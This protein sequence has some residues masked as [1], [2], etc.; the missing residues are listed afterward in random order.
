[1]CGHNSCAFSHVAACLLQAPAWLQPSR[2]GIEIYPGDILEA[3]LPAVM[4]HTLLFKWINIPGFGGRNQSTHPCARR[5][6][7]LTVFLQPNLLSTYCRPHTYVDGANIKPNLA[8]PELGPFLIIILSEPTA[9]SI[10]AGGRAL[11]LYLRCIFILVWNLQKSIW[12]TRGRGW[13]H[14][15]LGTLPFTPCWCIP[16]NTPPPQ[17]SCRG[18]GCSWG[19]GFSWGRGI[20]GAPRGRCKSG[21][22]V[23]LISQLGSNAW[24]PQLI[25]M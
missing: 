17:C 20:A 5:E 19:G 25:G 2:E 13:R 23:S 10:P 8:H 7:P 22:C 18:Q 3:F 11:Y 12:Q 1:M 14:H 6:R 9:G 15:L 4:A 16:L 21:C 24:V